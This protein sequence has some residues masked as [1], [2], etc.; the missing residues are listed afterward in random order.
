LQPIWAQLASKP[1]PLTLT[2]TIGLYSREG[3]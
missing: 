1:Q 3:V 2:L